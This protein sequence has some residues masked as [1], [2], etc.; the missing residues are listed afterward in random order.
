VERVVQTLIPEPFRLY[1]GNARVIE[2]PTGLCITTEGRFFVSDN[3]KCRVFQGRLHYPVDV[4][5][6]GTNLKNPQGFSVVNDVLYVADTG[7]KRVAYIP[8]SSS[9]FFKPNAMRVDDLRQALNER[10]ISMNR[11]PKKELLD[12]LRRWISDE[13]RACNVSLTNKFTSLPISASI[14]SPLAICGC[15]SDLLFISDLQ[16]HAIF[17]VPVMNNGAV[18]KGTVLSE[19]KLDVSALVYGISFADGKLYVADSSDRTKLTMDEI[20]H[21]TDLRTR[22]P[23]GSQQPYVWRETRFM[24]LIPPLVECV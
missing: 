1:K 6:L 20:L 16:R 8:L 14:V 17:Q 4:S 9:V 24:S 12:L 15:A 2:H 3:S 13:E 5:E 19:I 22:V 23:F 10:G 7:N 21:L 18:L 11:M